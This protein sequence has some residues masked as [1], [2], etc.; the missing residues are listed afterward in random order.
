M[1]KRVLVLDT[2][3]GNLTSVARALSRAGADVTVSGGASAVAS[4]DRLVVPG[5]GHFRDC[6]RVFDGALGDAVRE[7]LARERPYLGICLGMQILFDSS[8]E[9]PGVT[10]LGV[11]GGA[12]KKLERRPDPADPSRALKVPHMGW[13]LVKAR[14]PMLAPE[15]W[16]YF[17]H[18]YHCVADDRRVVV[19]TCEYGAEITAAVARGTLLAV[20]FHPEKSQDAGAALLEA[21][22]EDRWS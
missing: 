4:A 17:V 3:M 21:F 20:Q 6:A 22:V 11:F 18:S 15:A 19:G 7:H 10:G 13:N 16:L 1:T 5:Q 2:T 14:H 8:E 12:V 9:A